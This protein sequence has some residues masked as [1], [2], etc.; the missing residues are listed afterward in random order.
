MNKSTDIYIRKLIRQVI[1]ESLILEISA[2]EKNKAYAK[3]NE[4]VP[5]NPELMKQAI[6]QGREIGINFRSDNDKY[7]MPTTKSRIIQPVVYGVNN[8]GNQVVRGMHITGQSEKEAI[9]TGRRSAEIEFE[10]DGMNAWRVFK[11]KNIKSMWFTDRFFNNTP[12]GYNPND[13]HMSTIYV[14]YNP[15]SAKKYQ[16]EFISTKQQF[17]KNTEK[18][19]EQMGYE[20]QPIQEKNKNIKEFFK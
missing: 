1:S 20:N 9:K 17:N 3:S 6:L 19:I 5:F 14:S 18:D 4:R 13:N 15:V 10:K 8:L 11:V 16:D 2:E 12:P 7:T